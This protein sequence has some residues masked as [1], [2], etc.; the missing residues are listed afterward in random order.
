MLLKIGE[1]AKRTGLT[2]RTLHHYDAINLLRPSVRSAAGYRLYDRNDIE[3]LHRIQALRRLDLPLV[4]IATLLAG[5]T[6]DL[7]T[8][9]DR[10]IAQLEQEI[11]HALA[12]RDRLAALRSRLGSNNEADLGDWLDTLAMMELYHKHFSP[13]EL[14]R[15]PGRGQPDVRAMEGI[16][17]QVR[18]AMKRGV[19]PD[20]KEALRL[21]KPWL[22]L[23]LE[24][25]GGDTRLIHKLDTLLRQDDSLPQMAGID[26]GMLDYM[27]RVTAE[28]R[29]SL[30][31]RHLDAAVID[32]VRPRF[33]A[34][35]LDWPP[36]LAE[37]RELYE[38]SA[39]PDSPQVLALAARWIALFRA[40]WG[41]D[42][43][44]RE[45]VL[46]A[47]ALEPDIMA[48]VGL[49]PHM[50]EIVRA[51]IAH[52]QLQQQGKQQ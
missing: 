6:E 36:L 44:L 41:T 26:P 40:T 38:S 3:R 10:Q 2:V 45:R 29:L 20:S 16:I 39:A 1:L 43:A 9:I 13:E 14:Q 17:A 15:M 30:Y 23:S 4:D 19:P 35:Y 52:L 49:E 50:F 5:D 22:T 24:H 21:A 33:H 31:G 37:A 47:N 28:F 12:L 18:D 42:P 25:V 48:G 51:G 46:Q 32:E 8:V 7:Q 34:H 27:T 11:Q